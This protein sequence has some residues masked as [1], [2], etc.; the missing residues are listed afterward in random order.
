[1]TAG[2]LV[3]WQKRITGLRHCQRTR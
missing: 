1:M 3:L 2:P